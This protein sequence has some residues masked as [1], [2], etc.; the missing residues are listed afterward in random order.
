MDRPSS[1]PARCA[2]LQRLLLELTSDGQLVTA[3]DPPVLLFSCSPDFLEQQQQKGLKLK[4]GRLLHFS[5]GQVSWV[6]RG[7]CVGEGGRQVSWVR[8]G[9]CVGGALPCHV[10]CC[11]VC[12]LLPAPASAV[13]CLPLPVCPPA[14][15]C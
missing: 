11:Y 14:C 13:M 7:M 1:S 10:S 15:T 5:V 6:S 12:L 8:R 4:P 2:L 3:D 9:R